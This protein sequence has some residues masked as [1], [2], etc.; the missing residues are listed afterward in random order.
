MI[1]RDNDIDIIIEDTQQ[2]IIVIRNVS[3]DI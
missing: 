2:Y 3:N 1:A